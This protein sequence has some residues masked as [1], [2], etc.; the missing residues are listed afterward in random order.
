MLDIG[1]QLAGPGNA[2]ENVTIGRQLRGGSS[3]GGDV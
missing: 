1:I 3:K 2:E